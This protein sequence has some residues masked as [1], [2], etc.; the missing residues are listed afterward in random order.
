MKN[1]WIENPMVKTCSSASFTHR[2]L[3]FLKNTKISIIGDISKFCLW[4]N[5]GSFVRLGHILLH[6]K[7]LT[8]CLNFS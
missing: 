7:W 8:A 1:S 3:I 4:A 5:F 2:I 6:W